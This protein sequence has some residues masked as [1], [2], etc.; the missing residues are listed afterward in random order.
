MSTVTT[1]KSIILFIT[2]CSITYYSDCIEIHMIFELTTARGCENRGSGG[3]CSMS[4][5]TSLNSIN[6]QYI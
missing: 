5:V 3:H 4:T 2:K 6:M 1:F